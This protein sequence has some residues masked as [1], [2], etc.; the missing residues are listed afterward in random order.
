M[1]GVG[2]GCRKGVSG[3]E[4]ADLVRRALSEAGVDGPAALF[5]TDRKADEKGL[6]DA[7]QLLNMPLVLVKEEALRAVAGAAA[8]A[9]SALRFLPSV[10]GEPKPESETISDFFVLTFLTL[11]DAMVLEHCAAR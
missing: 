3:A 7:A 10:L 8:A 11:A 9:R 5:S 6:F 4:I 2:I 1:I